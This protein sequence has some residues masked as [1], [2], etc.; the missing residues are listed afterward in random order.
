MQIGELE[1]SALTLNQGADDETAVTASEVYPYGG[2]DPQRPVG[3]CGQDEQESGDGRGHGGRGCGGGAQAAFDFGSSER[4]AVERSSQQQRSAFDSGAINP[5]AWVAEFWRCAP[6]M[7]EALEHNDGAHSLRDVFD[8]IQ[9]GRYQFWPAETCVLVSEIL[10]FPQKKVFN[11]FLVGGDGNAEMQVMV[12]YA[13]AW[14]KAQGCKSATLCGRR[15][16]ER[17]K[18]LKDFGYKS[19]QVLMSKEL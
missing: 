13:E 3:S 11:Y 9:E 7:C 14:A 1:I 15:G 18:W 10:L 8:G 6:W 17:Q 4:N 5:P 19:V 2:I 16:W 12:P